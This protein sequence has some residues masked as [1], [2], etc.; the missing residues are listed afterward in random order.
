MKTITMTIAMLIATMFFAPKV[1][2]AFD[3]VVPLTEGYLDECPLA[4]AFVMYDQYG[5]S[6]RTAIHVDC[7]KY[8]RVKGE[9]EG[10][11]LVKTE[12]HK[13]WFPKSVFVSTDTGVYAVGEGN[14]VVIVQ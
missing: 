9:W 7:I 2:S 6:S 13:F 14:E 3:E 11:Q 12:K 10:Y 5:P 8:N 4:D 1:C